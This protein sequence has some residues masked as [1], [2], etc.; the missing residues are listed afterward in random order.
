MV[1]IVFQSSSTRNL[2]LVVVNERWRNYIRAEPEN[3]KNCLIFD[4]KSDH[5]KVILLRLSAATETLGSM[6]FHHESA[7][8]DKHNN[9]NHDGSFQ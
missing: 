3:V 4:I 5:T 6:G 9:L 2:F 7:A 1:T 8:D